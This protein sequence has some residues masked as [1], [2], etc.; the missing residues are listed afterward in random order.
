MV[1][2]EHN[3]FI[4]CSGK[5]LHAKYSQDHQHEKRSAAEVAPVKLAQY[6]ACVQCGKDKRDCRKTAQNPRRYLKSDELS[7]LIAVRV[8][9]KITYKNKKEPVCDHQTK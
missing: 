5:K 4:Y 2:M 7:V 8:C 6:P 9:V 1:E 3:P